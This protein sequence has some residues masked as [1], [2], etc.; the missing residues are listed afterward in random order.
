MAHLH[1][2]EILV[3]SF[4]PLYKVMFRSGFLS[5][6]FAQ[7]ILVGKLITECLKKTLLP[8]IVKMPFLVHLCLFL[9][10]LGLSSA[11]RFGSFWLTKQKGVSISKH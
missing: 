8:N 11:E 3:W 5:L 6:N 9:T 4:G 10:G 1:P 7:N 2:F